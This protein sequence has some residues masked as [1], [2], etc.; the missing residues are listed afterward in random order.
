MKIKI[1]KEI[2]DYIK[3]TYGEHYSTKDGF[4]VQDMLRH[5]NIDKDFA[6]AN[7]LSIFADLVRKQVV[8]EKDY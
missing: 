6:Q 2:H 3:G 5:L 8:I 1:I 4:Q 7:V